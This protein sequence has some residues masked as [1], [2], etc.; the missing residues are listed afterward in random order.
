MHTAAI[1]LIVNTEALGDV[2]VPRSWA[3]LLKPAYRGLVAY[4]DPTWGGT[5]Y[6]FVYGINA[7][8]GGSADD[9]GPGLDY[10]AKLDANVHSYPR[11]SIYND[12]LRG[13]VPIWI[14]ADG[15]GYKMR[16]VD[17]GPVEV[18]IPAEGSVS[19]PLVMGMAA[20]APHPRSTRAYLDWLLTPP[21][22]AEF[23]R[24]YF[25]P[26]V[27]GTTPPDVAANFLPD[28]EYARVRNLPLADMAAASDA[29]KRAWEARIRR[30]GRRRNGRQA[31]RRRRPDERDDEEPRARPQ[32]AAGPSSG[33]EATRRRRARRRRGADAR[34]W[35]GV[36][37]CLPLLVFLLLAFVVPLAGLV[38]QSLTATPGVLGR[39]LGH[40]T[41]ATLDNYRRALSPA[42]E[43]A[44]FRNSLV[45]SAAVAVLSLLLC[46]PPAWLLA[47][48][49]FRGAAAL[50]TVLALP[51]TF[52]GVIVGFLAVLVLGRLGLLPALLAV[53]TGER[54]LAG[55]AYTLGG[56]VAAYVYFEVP[57]AVLTLEAAFR[58]LDPEVEE[59]AATLGAG[60]WARWRLVWL[61][62]AAPAL[63]ST[64]AVTFAASM[65]SFGVALVL[66]RRLSVVPLSIYTQ[67][68]GFLD[69]GLAA[70]LCLLLAA[71]TLA[72]NG[73]LRS[74]VGGREWIYG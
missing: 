1:A 29:F 23:A 5:A 52:S 65:G 31:V 8:M 12:V 17:G 22:Q 68:T 53:L 21:A 40:V 2:P 59:A 66:A 20:G 13:E 11:E 28:S 19:M 30:G 10:L 33:G 73:L 45:L 67:Y 3:D 58:R 44:A 32:P 36:A 24:A 26:V 35:L 71:V 74:A 7:L 72:A 46:L 39:A 70:A 49:R 57:R 9:F 69:S 37:L 16:Y 6:T 42:G 51:L 4:D 41:G 48:H 18:V 25:R 55:S 14:N 64:L 56:L 62:L 38:P 34:P 60:G 15:N 43:L 27:P 50:R 54:W 63:A 47:R 61:P